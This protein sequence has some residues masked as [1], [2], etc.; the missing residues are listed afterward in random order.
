MRKMQLL[1]DPFNIIITG[2]GGRGNVTASRVLSNMLALKGY[3]VAVGETFGASQWGG[4]VMSH[5]RVSAKSVRS[6]QIPVRKADLV[7]ALEPLEAIRVLEVYGNENVR[8]LINTRPIYPMDVIAGEPNYPPV[9]EIAG[10]VKE[11]ASIAYFVNAT[12]AAMRLDNPI[13]GNIIMV[14]AMSRLGGLLLDREDFKAVILDT[15][16]ETQLDITLKAFDTGAVM[17][18]LYPEDMIRGGA[19]PMG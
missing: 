18:K 3:S 6:P 10:M 15:V 5:V 4:S 13:L 1:K 7:V 14:G 17:L 16:P 9:E 19:S 8:V 12:D 11:S 2:S